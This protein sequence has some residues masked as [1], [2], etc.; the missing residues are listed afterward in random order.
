MFVLAPKRKIWESLLLELKTTLGH[1]PVISGWAD[2]LQ[3]QPQIAY[4][5][6]RL[7]IVKQ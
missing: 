5:S 7:Q 1:I 4:T 6:T 3:K 2:V